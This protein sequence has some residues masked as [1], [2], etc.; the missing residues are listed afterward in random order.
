MLEIKSSTKDFSVKF[1]TKLN[2]ITGDV[3]TQITAGINLPK[4]HCAV[5]MCFKTNIFNFVVAMSNNKNSSVSVV[6]ILAKI[7]EED[8]KEVNAKVG[9]KIIIDRSSL[10]RGVHL[11]LP[12]MITS[13]NAK[14]YFNSDPNLTKAIVT[15]DNNIEIDPKMN[16]QLIAANS[17][18]IIVLEFKIVPV[19]AISASIANDVKVF[20]PFINVIKD[21]VGQ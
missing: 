20:D 9:E 3:L 21:E 10:E 1:P 11:N 2:E 8:S 13:N 15:R 6:P 16:K 17:P 14:S 19:N 18:E 7:S 5:A 4:Y 12:T